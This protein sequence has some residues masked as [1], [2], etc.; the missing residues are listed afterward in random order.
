MCVSERYCA[1]RIR[2]DVV[3]LNPVK[4][5]FTDDRNAVAP[6]RR[7]YVARGRRGSPDGIIA[8]N[9]EP[10]AVTSVANGGRSSGVG[11]NA[12]TPNKAGE[13]QTKINAAS[14]IAGDQISFVQGGSSDLEPVE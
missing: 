1:G 14:D 13:A 5:I 9:V 4:T 6:I 8:C 2:A 12:I 3:S 11:T 7:D 10:D